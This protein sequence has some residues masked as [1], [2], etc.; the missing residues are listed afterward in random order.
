MP[1][2]TTSGYLIR[3]VRE[4]PTVPCPC[5]LS[6]RPLTSTDTPVCNLHITF[7]TDSVKHYHKA[8]TEVY[9]ILEGQGKMEL[10]D[11]VVAIEPGMV[12]YIEPYTWHRL[13]SP[14][15]VRTIVFGVPAYRLD[16]EFYATEDEAAGAVEG[17]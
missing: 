14:Q 13:Y 6:T 3:H 5:G 15:G 10:N 7:I 9:Y 16:D 1:A 4:A 11:D 8:C 12:I 17:Q 2:S